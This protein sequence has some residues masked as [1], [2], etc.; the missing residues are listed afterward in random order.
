[1]DIQRNLDALSREPERIERPLTVVAII[2]TLVACAL[3]AM[4]SNTS[5]E[6]VAQPFVTN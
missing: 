5:V 6:R 3:Y 1:M 2:L 4:P